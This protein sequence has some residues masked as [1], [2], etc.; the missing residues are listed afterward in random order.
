MSNLRLR[1]ALRDS[2]GGRVGWDSGHPQDGI[3]QVEPQCS[4][5]LE[6]SFAPTADSTRESWKQKRRSVR[7]RSQPQ[8]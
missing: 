6:A 5:A 3:G 4:V 2:P 8:R 1:C 7:I